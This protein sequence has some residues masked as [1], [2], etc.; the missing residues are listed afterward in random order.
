MFRI[1]NP[2][3]AHGTVEWLFWAEL[4]RY[5]LIL[6]LALVVI[7]LA[8]REAPAAWSLFHSHIGL[9]KPYGTG[10]FTDPMTT[11]NRFQMAGCVAALPLL[12]LG[13]WGWKSSIRFERTRQDEQ[14]KRQTGR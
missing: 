6:A 9:P 1:S 11:R 13:Y 2:A 4:R 5:V 12:A 7:F 10:T 3:K 14:H 8:W